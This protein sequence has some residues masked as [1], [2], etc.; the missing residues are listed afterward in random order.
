[1]TNAVRPGGRRWL[2][3]VVAPAVG[4]VLVSPYLLLDRADS[5]IDVTGEAH[6]AVLVAHIFPAFIALVLGPLQ[7]VPAVRARR[8]AHRAI[9]RV[10]LLAG[11]LPAALAAV[12]VALL[13]GRL[14]TQAGLTAAAVLWLITGFCAYRAVR[15]SDYARHREWMMRNYA[16]TF[17]AVTSR[18]LVPLLLLA[19]IPFTH[20]GPGSMGDRAR[21]LIPLGQTLGWLVNLDAAEILIRRRRSRGAGTA[22][23]GSEYSAG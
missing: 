23:R 6:Y 5:R 19:E 4:V 7:F 10:Y 12:P 21:S 15:R 17:L 20:T 9:G 11:V 16:L 8:R 13:S 1:V 2:L 18:A 22:R 3:A 14:L